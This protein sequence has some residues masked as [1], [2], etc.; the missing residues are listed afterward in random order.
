MKNKILIIGAGEMQVPLIKK[1]KEMGLEVLV[2]DISKDAPGLLLADKSFLISTRDLNSNLEIAEKYNVAGV[3]TSSD[4]PVNTVAFISDALNLPGLSIESA[5]YCTNKYLQKSILIDAGLSVPKFNYIDTS[6]DEVKNLVKSNQEYVLK[7]LSSSGSRGVHKIKAPQDFEIAIRDSLK[8]SDDSFLILEE[9]IDGE[10]FS[11]EMLLQ[12]NECHI[13]AITEKKLLKSDSVFVEKGHVIPAKIPIQIENAIRNCAKETVRVLNLNNC[14]VHLELKVNEN[15]KIYIIEVGARL[16]GDF[17]TSH[18]IPLSKGID[19][20]SNVI[21]I[22]LG[23][24]ININPTI[25]KFSGVKFITSE[26]YFEIEK[27]IQI[28]RINFI[29]KNIKD[30]VLLSTSN[31]MDRLGYYIVQEDSREKLLRQLNYEK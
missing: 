20:L 24:E 8:Y 26:D 18:L 22:S 13:I 19:M 23:Q 14:A 3:I 17:I 16:G 9:Y 15:G 7:P 10:E 12:D 21:K 5:K 28:N 30:Y 27:F 6:K 2:S 11:V 1:A 4:Y 29:E 31:S 25:V